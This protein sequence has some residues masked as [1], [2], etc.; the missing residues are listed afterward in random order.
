MSEVLFEA[1][2]RTMDNLMRGPHVIVR[3]AASRFAKKEAPSTRKAS[4]NTVI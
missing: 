4:K 1:D 2:E 3:T